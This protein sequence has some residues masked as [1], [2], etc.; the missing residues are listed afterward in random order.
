MSVSL[1]VD[2]LQTVEHHQANPEHG[3]D[4]P[5]VLAAPEELVK[6]GSEPINDNEPQ[7]D[8]V[9]DKRS[10]GLEDGHRHRAQLTVPG[11]PVRPVALQAESVHRVHLSEQGAVVV[12]LKLHHKLGVILTRVSL[13]N[14]V[15]V[16]EAP[17]SYRLAE[18]PLRLPDI[19][20]RDP[21]G[22]PG[23]QLTPVLGHFGGLGLR[24][25]TVAN[26]GHV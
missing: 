20:H 24:V 12:G 25:R 23:R 8:L 17:G 3:V 7:L 26:F 1:A 5:R 11:P 10:A 19:R 16:S 15:N 13:T 14:Q 4:G 21:R 6:V 22:Q 18:C 2:I 9:M